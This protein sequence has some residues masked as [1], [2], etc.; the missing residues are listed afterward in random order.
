MIANSEPEKTAPAPTH[1]ERQSAKYETVFLS[2]DVATVTLLLR[3]VAASNRR[4]LRSLAI[5]KRNNVYFFIFISF[6]HFV[7]LV[8]L[9]VT[10]CF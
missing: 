8:N 9:L 3:T 2:V 10:K 4:A 1:A 7:L 6:K 5:K